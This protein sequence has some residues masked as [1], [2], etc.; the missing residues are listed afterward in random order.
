MHRIFRHDPRL[1][2]LRAERDH[3]RIQL[4]LLE[5]R[6]PTAERDVA[7]GLLGQLRSID[8]EI[9]RTQRDTRQ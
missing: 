4:S 7:L 1:E 3:L 6:G 9:T 8:D 5:E 2:A